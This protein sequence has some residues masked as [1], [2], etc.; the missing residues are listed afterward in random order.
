MLKVCQ[1]DVIFSTVMLLLLLL[2]L[3]FEVLSAPSFLEIARRL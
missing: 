1:L 2:L 3:W